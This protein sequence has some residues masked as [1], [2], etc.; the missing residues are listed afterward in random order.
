MCPVDRKHKVPHN[1]YLR[2]WSLLDWHTAPFLGAESRKYFRSFESGSA[3]LPF[4]I[5]FSTRWRP[6][7]ST[8]VYPR[9]L[10]TS[11][12]DV[13][14][15]EPASNSG[16]IAPVNMRQHHQ[17]FDDDWEDGWFED[18]MENQE[19][20]DRGEIIGG[21]W[22]H[23]HDDFGEISGSWSNWPPARIQAALA[24]AL[25]LR[26]DGN[27]AFRAGDYKASTKLYGDA[28]YDVSYLKSVRELGGIS[29]S[30]S[31]FTR[32]IT[33]MQFKACSN[34]AAS[35]LKYEDDVPEEGGVSRFQKARNATSG[36]LDALKDHPKAW[37][38]GDKEMARLLYRRAL[39]CEGLGD[40]EGAEKE[41]RKAC[42]LSPGDQSLQELKSKI[43]N[44]RNLT[45][46]V[47]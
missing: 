27:A 23:A 22:S 33:E 3:N 24:E 21:G 19:H 9:L 47:I 15:T 10:N 46:L 43:I 30:D 16:D 17:E 36:A 31:Q 7:P 20:D 35:L 41:I 45:K 25:K 28:R 26:E 18:E 5:A 34:E 39:A 42:E 14:Q 12:L 32:T 6:W 38:P 4:I 2:T 37:K 29:K 44:V 13:T 40:F 11:S 8:P 1:N